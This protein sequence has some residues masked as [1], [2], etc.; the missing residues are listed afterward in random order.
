MAGESFNA[1]YVAKTRDMTSLKT[2]DPK[3]HAMI[4]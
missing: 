1:R 4:A 3:D 2:L